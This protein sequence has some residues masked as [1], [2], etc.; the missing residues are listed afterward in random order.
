M[1]INFILNNIIPMI[2]VGFMLCLSAALIIF[3]S[4]RFVAWVIETI[5]LSLEFG[6]LRKGREAGFVVKF[7]VYTNDLAYHHGMIKVE[8]VKSTGQVEFMNP[9]TGRRFFVDVPDARQ[10]KRNQSTALGINRANAL[11]WLGR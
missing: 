10:A 11:R 5:Q 6:R 1:D 3:M 7:G 8:D 2:A 9:H 4:A